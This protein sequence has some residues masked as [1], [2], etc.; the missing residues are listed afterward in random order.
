[1]IKVGI[2]GTGFGKTHA[3]IYS[4]L[5]NVKIEGVFGRTEEKLKKLGDELGVFVT[6]N[7]D[8]IIKNPD[9]N[10]ID[11]CLPTN[12]HK[13]YVVKSLE[14]GKDVFCETP[15]C[16]TL[17]EAEV[18]KSCAE[19]NNKKIFVDLFFKFSDPHRI[20]IE[21][22]KTKS[23]G[24]PL[25]ITAYQKTPPHWGNMDL[26]KIVQDFMLHNFDFI[27]EIKGMPQSLVANGYYNNN[28]HICSTLE[29]E[30]GL[31]SVES[32]TLLPGKFPFNIGFTIICEHGTIY[33]DGKYGE[34]TKQEMKIYKN[35]EIKEVTLPSN[36]DYEE[37]IK[38]VI[39][40][41][42]KNKNSSII[43][44]DEAIKSLNIVLAI[45]E[46]LNSNC[47]VSLNG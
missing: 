14:N 46:S 27:T 40:H 13:K 37:A 42:E 17:E 47:T 30:D 44:I 5:K 25:T 18:M 41:I 21:L 10:L 33:F 9:I 31:A 35:E 4:K 34:K 19:K 22:I 32:S 20:A 6:N 12:V 16:Y 38:H 36:D 23:L 11:V 39:S 7:I 8:D 3:N 2:L 1:M 45:K 43:S 28:S 29:Y 24:K 15:I 26:D